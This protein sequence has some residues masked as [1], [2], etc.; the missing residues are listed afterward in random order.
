MEITLLVFKAVCGG[1]AECWGGTSRWD[2]LFTAEGAREG[3]THWDCGKSSFWQR[4]CRHSVGGGAE[5]SSSISALHLGCQSQG[6]QDQG[7]SVPQTDVQSTT[8]QLP[9]ARNLAQLKV[10][11]LV[12]DILVDLVRGGGNIIKFTRCFSI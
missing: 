5:G 6:A 2:A 7:C 10:R 11:K 4:A 12:P 8:L 3:W 9:K 1:E